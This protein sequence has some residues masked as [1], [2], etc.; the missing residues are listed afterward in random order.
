[1]TQ[2]GTW[3]AQHGADEDTCLAYSCAIKPA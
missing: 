1:M 2:T 3:L